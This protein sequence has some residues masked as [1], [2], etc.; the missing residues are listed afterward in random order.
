LDQLLAHLGQARAELERTLEAE[1]PLEKYDDVEADL[2]GQWEEE[3]KAAVEAEYRRRRADL[4]AGLQSW[5]RDVWFKTLRVPNELL[6]VGELAAQAETVAGR[7]SARDAL[8]NT[9]IL[10]ELQRL[11]STN[12]QEALALEVGLLRLRL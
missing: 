10:D 1:S 3:L 2:R 12:V 8:R 4:L 6:A 5:L 11:L 7:I 9:E